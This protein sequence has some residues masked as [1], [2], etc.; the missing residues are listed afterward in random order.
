M[1]LLSLLSWTDQEFIGRVTIW[2]D[3]ANGLTPSPRLYSWVLDDLGVD[4]PRVAWIPLIHE[5]EI[6][7]KVGPEWAKYTNFL[8]PFPRHATGDSVKDSV[9]FVL[10]QYANWNNASDCDPNKVRFS[11]SAASGTTPCGPWERKFTRPTWTPRSRKWSTMG[12]GF[13][14]TTSGT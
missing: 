3:T 7:H 14:W 4:S 1:L 6:I 12:T 5:W 13:S 10:A 11:A 8:F 9:Y 2:S